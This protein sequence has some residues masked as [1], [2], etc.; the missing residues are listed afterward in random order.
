VKSRTAGIER[1]GCISIDSAEVDRAGTGPAGPGGCCTSHR[2]VYLSVIKPEEDA[3]CA[4]ADRHLRQ[5]WTGLEAARRH[6]RGLGRP[7]AQARTQEEDTESASTVVQRS[8]RAT[9]SQV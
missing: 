2:V 7:R 4:G 6:T 5:T 1:H 3:S 9:S 8:S